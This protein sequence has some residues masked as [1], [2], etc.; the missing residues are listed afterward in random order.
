MAE[1]AS[2]ETG[3]AEARFRALVEQLPAIVWTLTLDAQNTYVSPQVERIFGTSVDEWKRDPGMWK[4]RLHPEDRERVLAVMAETRA[5]GTG[6]RCEYRVVR[7]DGR[8]VWLHDE[9][10]V[11]RDGEGR[12]LA[13]Q[14][15]ALDITERKR[16]EAE[17]AL[18]ARERDT[19]H[20]ISHIALSSGPLDET[21]RGIIAEVIAATGFPLAA[22]VLY[23]EGRGLLC[24]RGS[25][26]PGGDL[27]IGLGE[28]LSGVVVQTGKPFVWTQG[29]PLPIRL[30]TDLAALHMRT[31]LGV[32]MM[33]GG[34]VAGALVIAD[35]AV[36]AVD[37]RLVEFLGPIANHVA[38]L[39]E[40][41]QAQ[42][43]RETSERHF[44]AVFDG[45]IDAMIVLDDTG[46]FVEVNKAAALLFGVPAA[47]LLTRSFGDLAAPGT[48]VPEWEAL[49]AGRLRT[50]QWQ[51]RRPDGS[52][53]DAE[54]SITAHFLPGRHLVV[55]RD[56]TERTGAD[57]ERRVRS[58]AL[59]AA[60]NGILITDADGRVEWVNP[61][62]TRMTGYALDEIRGQMPRLLKSGEQDDAFYERVWSTIRAGHVW[63]GEL[64]NRRKDGSVYLEEQSITPVRAGGRSSGVITHFVAV[65]QDIS[66]RKRAEETLRRSE[67]YHRA[68]IENGLDIII[69]LDADG[70]IRY[71]S[72]SVERVL[73]ERPGDLVGTN[74]LSRLHP[75]D[76]PAMGALFFGGQ[77]TAGFTASAEYRFRHR[78]G[79]WRQM[80]GV[81]RNLLDHPGIAGI[82]VNARDITD[83]KQDEANQAR[84]R[85]HLRQS[86][87]LAAMSELLAGVAH[88]LNNPL[89]VV[90]GHT[91][92]LGAATEP[93][94]KAR[95][96]KI[97]RAAERCG[98]IVKNF[99]ALARQY[100]PERTAVNLNQIVV[101]ALEVVAYPLRVDDVEVVTEL[102]ADLPPLAADPHQLQQV[103][104]NLVTNAHQAMRSVTGT[105]RLTVRTG[106][107]DGGP[108]W[109]AVGDTGPGI[110]AE[111]EA[112]LFEPFF[113]TKPVGQ[114]TGLGLSICKG[115]V[116]GHGGS[117][118]VEAGP[119][120]GAVFRVT[121]PLGAPAP[122]AA[123]PDEGVRGPARRV[124][125]VD[126]EIE[127]TRIVSEMLGR[128]GHEVESCLNGVEALASMQ[129]RS[130]DVVFCD[131]RMPRLDGP[132]LYAA[133]K[134]TDPAL[135]ERF[136]F[137]TGDTLSHVTAEFLERTGVP[138]MRKPF[139]VRD[140]RNAL[141]RVAPATPREASARGR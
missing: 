7:D 72:P 106:C 64:V 83:R 23:D 116:E 129:T 107:S 56:V 68:L 54:S 19:M 61:E 118:T 92:L 31:F 34:R 134:Q 131:I 60:A 66:E 8:V 108:A 52:V 2:G 120:S 49:R 11:V 18:R 26:R 65:K 126:D 21:Y 36:R 55:V 74:A 125:V 104:V 110:P 67:E 62:F 30:H 133:V 58:A 69:V 24:S 40:R 124:L 63:R 127:V 90:I 75:D 141:A 130:Y 13:L 80:E 95:A 81:G 25:H 119:G 122:A 22:I 113:T 51:L 15:V 3:L 4:R 100:P 98:R 20:R 53:R 87:K 135:A 6:Y 137:L 102:A 5:A 94:V 28:G 76:L 138:N 139:T 86:E 73:G 27:E 93:A 89:S 114:G 111:V 14:G 117:L 97:G 9:A 10:V 57:A 33:A 70:V 109:L 46:R 123:A 29:E 59:T 85:A 50:A 45:A 32:P 78:D 77:A 39:I 37:E 115:I 47:E 84:L 99:L 38:M 136:V 41:A 103:L 35:T 101:D 48:D 71:A 42:A 140:L 79:S 88:E 128:D 17:V 105:R 44:L 121:L 96:E 12:P 132:G 16:A 82:I 43:A 112:R 1:R 91:T